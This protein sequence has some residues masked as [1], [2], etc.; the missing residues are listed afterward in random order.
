MTIDQRIEK[1]LLEMRRACAIIE[2]LNLSAARE[3]N[4]GGWQSD[5][6]AAIREEELKYNDA[7]YR[8]ENYQKL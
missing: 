5:W 3:E 7:K 8:L 4:L 1:E 6:A 2:H